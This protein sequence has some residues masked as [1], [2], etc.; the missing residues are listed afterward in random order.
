MKKILS[1]L[2]VLALMLALLV[3]CSAASTGEIE[4]TS[5]PTTA[6]TS[7]AD[8]PQTPEPTT[9]PTPESV[10]E[11]EPEPDDTAV[12]TLDDILD[13][14]AVVIGVLDGEYQDY[15]AAIAQ[16]IAQDMDVEAEYIT[17][18]DIDALTSGQVD[19]M[20]GLHVTDENIDLADFA[21]PYMEIE[22]AV[23]SDDGEDTAEPV[24]VAP[25]VASGNDGL[26]D[27]LDDEIIALGDDGFF[28]DA[29]SAVLESRDDDAALDADI[30]NPYTVTVTGDANLRTGPGMDYDIASKAEAD[31]GLICIGGADG[32]LRVWLDEH[33]LY[34]AVNLVSEGG[35]DDGTAGQE[36]GTEAPAT[37]AKADTGSTSGNGSG[38]SGTGS[39]SSSQSG[40]NS[41]STGSGS[42]SSKGNTGSDS[43]KTDAG[44][45]GSNGTSTGNSGSTGSGGTT[46]TSTPKPEA[47]K[48]PAA[49]PAPTKAP[50]ATKQPTETK[51][52]EPT[53]KPTQTAS[54]AP[55]PKPVE[56]AK[57]TPTPAPTPVPHTHSWEPV[58]KTVHHDE[59]GH[60]ETVTITEA[61]DETTYKTVYQCKSCGSQ[62][63]SLN[64]YA[65]HDDIVHDSLGA[66]Y[67]VLDV[68]NGT[69]H[70]DAVTEQCW[71]VDT[72]AWDERVVS[73][74]KCSCGATK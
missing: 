71:V 25:A 17:L 36:T 24:L 66:G 40:T 56:T 27:W 59:V 31:S 15:H 72:A 18:D 12:R 54:P 42:S 37:E 10:P 6:P 48:T 62:F 3:G 9:E 74:Y 69:I 43:N 49:T 73:G 68:P 2:T 51:T 4:A 7:A 20:F 65:D 63:N 41:G 14:G 64:S 60:Y 57:P 67:A 58:Y 29:Y 53:D 21:V 8:H 30:I 23:A 13:A 26:L 39:G 34:I 16:R 33:G 61:W 50:E 45:G 1:L 32:W 28:T 19:I 22:L 35:D 55:T 11:D 5:E 44:S 38:S 52:P 46:A 70:H 47:T